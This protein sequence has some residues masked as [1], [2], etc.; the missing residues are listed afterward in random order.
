[1]KQKIKTFLLLG[2]LLGLFCRTFGLAQADLLPT[3]WQGS[4]NA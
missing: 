3:I 1:M 2:S 4:L